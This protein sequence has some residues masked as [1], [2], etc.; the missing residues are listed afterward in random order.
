MKGLFTKKDGTTLA[1][2]HEEGSK[3]TFVY[4]HGFMSSLNAHKAKVVKE[5]C[6]ESGHAYFC[7]DATGHGDS[8][9]T[10]ADISVG[11]YLNDALEITDSLIQGDMILV[12]SSFGGW[13][14]ELLAIQRPEKVKGIVGLCSAVDF[15]EDVWNILKP[16]DKERLKKEKVIGPSAETKGYC[17]TYHLFEEGREHLLLQDK[18]RYEGDVILI[19][20]DKDDQV[21]YKKDFEIKEALTTENVEIWILKGSNHYLATEKDTKALTRALKEMSE[22]HKAS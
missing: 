9:G 17:W 2:E 7:F 3:P 20:G 11:N 4:C 6:R 16:E 12:G 13:I 21:S 15:T 1:Y 22:R 14:V 18:I 10:P 8:S 5:F 19:H